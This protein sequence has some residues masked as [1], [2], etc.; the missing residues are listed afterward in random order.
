[1]SDFPALP[2]KY[3][4][5][6][7]VSARHA[8]EEWSELR[9]GAADLEAVGAVMVYDNAL[10][11][12]LLDREACERVVFRGPGRHHRL[13]RGGGRVVLVGDFGFGAP[14]AAAVLEVL[15]A[16]GVERII[17]IGTAGALQPALRPGDIIGVTGAVRDDGTSWHYLPGDRPVRPHADLSAALFERLGSDL[18]TTGT[19]WT[20][21]AVYRETVAELVHHRAHGVQAVEMEAA[22]LMAVSEVRGAAVASAVCVSDLLTEQGWQAMF[23]APVVRQALVTLF[24]AAVDT[25]AEEVG[26]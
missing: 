6:E 25:L 23:S 7:V 4:S 2:A 12:H 21:D 26:R 20:N 17:S 10:Y 9:V 18:V 8:V 22:A 5:V 13:A 3:S 11:R 1:M 15:I 16:A 14:V 19:V 24:D